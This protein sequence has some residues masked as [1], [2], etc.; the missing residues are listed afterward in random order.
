MA[1][2]GDGKKLELD[3]IENGK[4]VGVFKEWPTSSEQQTKMIRPPFFMDLKGIM[5]VSG[6]LEQE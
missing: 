2:G 4:P 5:W 3:V 1:F 6:K